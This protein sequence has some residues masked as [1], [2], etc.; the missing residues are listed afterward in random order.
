M[1]GCRPLPPP[2]GGAGGRRWNQETGEAASALWT[3][4]GRVDSIPHEGRFFAVRELPPGWGV[5]GGGVSG[6]VAAGGQWRS[7]VV[8]MA[9]PADNRLGYEPADEPGPAR[10]AV[11]RLH[12]RLAG[13]RLWH[14]GRSL[15]AHRPC[16]RW[17]RHP[18]TASVE[19]HRRPARSAPLPTRSLGLDH[20]GVA[21]RS[22]T[23]RRA[24]SFNRPAPVVGRIHRHG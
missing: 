5:M 21:G 24:A 7:I 22:L 9:G 15:V 6:A 11:G 4:T 13:L 23:A 18:R 10:A 2:G 20:S 8:P 17:L 1:V 12:D 16:G 19:V 3:F 14:N